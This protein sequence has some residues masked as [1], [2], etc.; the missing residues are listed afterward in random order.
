MINN[1]LA[2]SVPV[3]FSVSYEMVPIQLLL[4]SLTINILAYIGLR[5]G[6]I[7]LHLL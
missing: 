5:A 6:D 1:L 7:Y 4:Q 3:Y 2:I